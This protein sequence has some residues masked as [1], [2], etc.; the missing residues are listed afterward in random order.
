MIKIKSASEVLAPFENANRGD[1]GRDVP[2]GTVNWSS[3]ITAMNEHSKQVED[4]YRE[5]L[6]KKQ[7]EIDFKAYWLKFGLDLVLNG[8]AE[9]NNSTIQL[10]GNHNKK[11]LLKLYKELIDAID[12]ESIEN[13]VAQF[14]KYLIKNK[15]V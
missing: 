11:E 6:R 4:Y 12:P 1:F 8:S 13:V 14:D 15:K 5:V 9:A 10:K 2:N 7:V 3:A